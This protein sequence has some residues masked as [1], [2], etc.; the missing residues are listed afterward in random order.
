MCSLLTS[1]QRTLLRGWLNKVCES[2]VGQFRGTSQDTVTAAVKNQKTSLWFMCYEFVQWTIVAQPSESPIK[3]NVKQ[4]STNYY[5]VVQETRENTHFIKSK[6]YRNQSNRS[7][8]QHRCIVFLWFRFEVSSQ[9]TA[10][11]TEAFCGL[12]YSLQ[13]NISAIPP[14]RP[15]QI[16]FNTLY[17][18]IILQSDCV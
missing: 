17:S 12:L 15:W 9:R 11:I 5:R 4:T 18:L 16:P 13:V 6:V 2:P 3:R 14:L 10:I 8:W 7:S 1:R